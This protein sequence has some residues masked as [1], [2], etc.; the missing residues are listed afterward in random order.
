MVSHI[1]AFFSQYPFFY[2][3][4][5]ES[6]NRNF[7]R[8]CDERGWKR[9]DSERNDAYSEFKD[10]L[11]KEFNRKYGSD[12]H[13]LEAWQTLCRL[14]RTNP[15]PDTLEGCRQAIQAT[16]VNLVDLTEARDGRFV[17]TFDTEEELASYTIETGKFF[18]SESAYAGGLLRKLLRHI[19]TPRPDRG[20][21][22]GRSSHGRGRGRGRS[23]WYH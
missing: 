18:P 19:L 14:V 7:Y 2:Y 17:E 6:A 3:N 11:V 10:A 8:L 23:R 20:R 12:E 22:R 1:A 5:T 15:I 21:G 9:D 16:H 13:N 4:S